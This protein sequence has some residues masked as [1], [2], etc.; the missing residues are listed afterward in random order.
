LAQ[1]AGSTIDDNRIKEIDMAEYIFLMHDDAIDDD[2]AWGPYLDKLKQG[3]FFEGGSAIGHGVCARKSG[4]PLTAHLTGYIRVNAESLDQ[5]KS[6][7]IGNPL[8]EAAERWRSVNYRER[9]DKWL[10]AKQV[11]EN[12]ESSR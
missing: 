5:A 3:R 8:F 9:T 6:L 10:A 12:V 7:L 2:K 11:S 1:R 4:E